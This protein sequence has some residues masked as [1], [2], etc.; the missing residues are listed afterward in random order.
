MNND[1]VIAK[2]GR[3]NQRKTVI[4]LFAMEMGLLNQCWLNT[5]FAKSVEHDPGDA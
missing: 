3:L 1:V 4:R 5:A 2:Q